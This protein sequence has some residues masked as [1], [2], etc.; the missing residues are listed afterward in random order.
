MRRKKALIVPETQL[1]WCF[2]Q[3]LICS[4]SNKRSAVVQTTPSWKLPSDLLRYSFQKR[5]LSPKNLLHNSQRLYLRTC[6]QLILDSP[7]NLFQIFEEIFPRFLKTSIKIHLETSS[8]VTIL[9]LFSNFFKKNFQGTHSKKSSRE[10]ILDPLEYLFQI[11]QV[12]LT[13]FQ[14]SRKFFQEIVNNFL[15]LCDGA[16]R[17]LRLHL[18]ASE[19]TP[20]RMLGGSFECT[21][22][23][24]RKHF[25]V[26]C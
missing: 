2:S 11:L 24:W 17:Q 12:S 13:E 1:I 20:R 6:W 3:D 5:N 10:Q 8:S 18:F 15:L 14:K 9:D 26:L 7:Q 4:F 23:S 22:N 25:Y 16:Y 21:E 19:E